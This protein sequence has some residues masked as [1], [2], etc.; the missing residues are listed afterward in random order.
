[1]KS[2]RSTSRNSSTVSA[3]AL[4]TLVFLVTGCSDDGEKREYT[5][6]D[7]LCGT[8]VDSEALAPF[9]PGGNKITVRDRSY[10]G[11]RGCEVIVDDKLI[12]TTSQMWMEENRTT[13]FVAARQSLDTLDKSAEDGRF[14][15]SG[16]EAF[17][18]TL[19]C[20]DTKYKQELYTVI[21]ADGTKNRDAEAMKRLIL[22]FTESVEESA[23]CTAGAQ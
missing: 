5:V 8:A 4:T 1:M 10:S 14:V 3:A 17:G 12:V 11:S 13:S 23:E 20:V 7:T 2:H 15:Y 19:D 9:L 16:N 22:S 21:Q 18:K 6:P